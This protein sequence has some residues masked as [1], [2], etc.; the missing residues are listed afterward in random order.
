MA[1]S[2]PDA[3][4]E[5]L[6]AQ[7]V[8]Q[9]LGDVYND[10]H[11]PIGS[12][13]GDYED[14]LTSYERQ[15]LEHPDMEDGEGGWN[16]LTPRLD[17]VEGPSIL[18]EGVPWDSSVN[19]DPAIEPTLLRTVVEENPLVVGP[20]HGSDENHAGVSAE[21][22]LHHL[23]DP[24][25][26]HSPDKPTLTNPRHVSQ[27]ANELRS[28][29]I[30]A[31]RNITDPPHL[32]TTIHHNFNYPSEIEPSRSASPLAPEPISPVVPAR[33]ESPPFPS[34]LFRSS[35][36][37]NEL[38]LDWHMAEPASPDAS[39]FKNKGKA[40][41]DQ[42]TNE[43]RSQ[44]R[45]KAQATLSN[46][47]ESDDQGTASKRK[48]KGK[49][50]ADDDVDIDKDSDLGTDEETGL[51]FLRIPWPGMT[52]GEKAFRDAMERIVVEVR[53]G[54]EETVDSILM[55]IMERDAGKET[56]WC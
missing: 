32:E 2:V 28:P 26:Y 6:I 33:S 24:I 9:D 12:W 30:D 37:T 38:L 44:R 34:D 13:Y 5:A 46:S 3:A 4:T 25:H 48:G 56:V 43:E 14:P 50:R 16:P 42:F 15:V 22:P 20:E 47:W 23:N 41:A 29:T 54:E 19:E 31:R 8:A 55:G 45:A 51:P 52:P 35:I 1:S 10:A 36:A 11:R 7:L 18:A 39:P 21:E 53:V 40:P 27:P 49:A 17:P